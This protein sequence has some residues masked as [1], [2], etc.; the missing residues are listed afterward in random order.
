MIRDALNENGMKDCVIRTYDTNT[1]DLN[2]KNY[3]S[4]GEKIE[5]LSENL[6]ER[7]GTKIKEGS[8]EPKNFIQRSGRTLVLCDGGGKRFE[9]PSISP[10]LKSGDIIMAHDYAKDSSYFEEFINNKVWNWHEISDKNIAN[11]MKN[12]GLTKIMSKD[13]DPVVWVC[14]EKTH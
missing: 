1:S 12:H 3:I 8:V 9:V 4:K 14:L 10:F 11:C 7:C 13:F 5:F 6:F 2:L